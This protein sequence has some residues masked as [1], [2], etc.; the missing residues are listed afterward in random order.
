MRR[1][2][3]KFIF[4]FDTTTMTRFGG[5]VLFRQFCKS[6]DLRHFVQLYVRWPNY[7]HRSY[8]PAD[9]FLAHVFAIVAGIGRIENTP[10]VLLTTV[11][12]RPFLVYPTFL[13]ATLYGPSFGASTKG[14]YEAYN[15]LTTN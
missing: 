15:P 4:S 11:C 2:P 3:Q 13:I 6:L 10:K 7:S 9:L 1:G 14:A 5:L 12:F 8:H